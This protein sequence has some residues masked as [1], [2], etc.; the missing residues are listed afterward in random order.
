MVIVFFL[1]AFII[2]LILQILNI[3]IIIDL[4]ILKPFC[5]QNNSEFMI[6]LK[7]TPHIEIQLSQNSKMRSQTYSNHHNQSQQQFQA[8]DQVIFWHCKEFGLFW[9]WKWYWRLFYT[10][11]MILSHPSLISI[12]LYPI[13]DTCAAK[14]MSA[15]VDISLHKQKITLTFLFIQIAQ[16]TSYSC[17]YLLESL[18]IIQIRVLKINYFYNKTNMRRSILSKGL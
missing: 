5:I 4:I 12:Y 1:S 13:F 11:D 18:L 9:Y 15:T 16:S 8:C 6:S 17:I 14:L 10:K 7:I 2:V 3:A